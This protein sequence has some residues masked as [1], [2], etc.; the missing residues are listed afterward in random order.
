MC[1]HE[2]LMVK[3]RSRKKNQKIQADNEASGKVNNVYVFITT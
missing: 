2:L 1:T 3:D